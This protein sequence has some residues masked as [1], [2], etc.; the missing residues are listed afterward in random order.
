[1]RYSLG[2]NLLQALTPIRNATISARQRLADPEIGTRVEAGRI[3]VVRY[4][5]PPGKRSPVVTP[6]S[7][8]VSPSD[9]VK[10]LDAL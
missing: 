6:L 8:W 7:E 3:Q 10:T 2:M 5:F 1:M 4:H 9:A